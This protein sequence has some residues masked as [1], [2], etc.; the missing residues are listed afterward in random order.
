MKK[1][2]RASA[3]RVGLRQLRSPKPSISLGSYPGSDVTLTPQ[4]A[5]VQRGNLRLYLD[6]SSGRLTPNIPR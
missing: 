6:P 1:T 2:K 4:G 3:R 5:L